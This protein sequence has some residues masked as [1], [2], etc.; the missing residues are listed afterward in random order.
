MIAKRDRPRIGIAGLVTEVDH[1]PRGLGGWNKLWVHLLKA[2][3][4]D[5][6]LQPIPSSRP[7]FL[8]IPFP[9]MKGRHVNQIIIPFVTEIHHLLRDLPTGAREHFLERFGVLVQ[10]RLN[11]F[12]LLP[13][14]G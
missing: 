13:F 11:L 6:G 4:Q 1:H 5:R 12:V 2:S 8:N 7:L 9:E 14:F 10:P 3:W